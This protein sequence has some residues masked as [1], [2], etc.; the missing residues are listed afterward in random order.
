MVGEVITEDEI[1]ACTTCR[2]C[3]EICP[4]FIEHIDKIVDMRR[5]LV[6]DL[7]QVP[8]T[9]EAVLKCIEARGHIC[10][11]TTLTRT[12]WATGLDIKQLS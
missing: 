3:M 6:L 11:G 7:A 4:V 10:K 12:D 8:E 5:H 1:W 9:G 2:A